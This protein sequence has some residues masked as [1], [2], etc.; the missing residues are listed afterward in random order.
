MKLDSLGS[1]PGKLGAPTEALSIVRHT[2]VD[3]RRQLTP[4]P[5]VAPRGV[6][7]DGASP[8]DADRPR[9]MA[10]TIVNALAWGGLPTIAI[11]STQPSAEGAVHAESPHSADAAPQLPL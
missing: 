11:R 3:T 5:C 7:T 6:L 9:R 8:Q 4:E 10:R 1:R 2:E